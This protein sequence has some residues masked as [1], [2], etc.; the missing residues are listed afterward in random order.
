MK[1]IATHRKEIP[2]SSWVWNVESKELS[3][4]IT[5]LKLFGEDADLVPENFKSEILNAFCSAE[6]SESIP[7]YRKTSHS[8]N[9]NKYFVEWLGEAIERNKDGGISK[10]AGYAELGSSPDDLTLSLNEEAL[11]FTRLMDN[12]RESVYFKDLESRFIRINKACAEKFGLEDPSE[13]VGK[14]D[15]DFFDD[16]HAR[17][18]FKDEQEIIRTE[19]PLF[20]KIE[21]EV[22]AGDS[23][24]VKWASTSK[25]PLYDEKGV[26]I[27]TY[28]ITR[29][30]TEEQI[31]KS[32][33]KESDEMFQRLSEHVPG[34]FY[35]YKFNKDGT[36]CFPFAS[37]GIKHIYELEP[38]DVKNNVDGI[39]SRI[40]PEDRK[41]FTN[42]LKKAVESKSEW[43]CDYR[44]QLPKKGTRWLRGNAT[45]EVEKDN[46]IL[47]YGYIKDI[48][49][50][51]EA[52]EKLKNRN[53]LFT[54]LSEQAP[55]FLYLHRV[56]AK[57]K[58]S[59]PFVSEG[60]REVLEL[61]PKDLRSS[62]KPL[63]RL[64]QKEDIARVMKSITWS[65]KTQQEWSCEFRVIL[66]RK[67]LRW[68]RGRANP[69]LQSDGAVL[70][71]GFLSDITREKS[72]SE[73]ND[74]LRKQFES[75]LDNV[76]N[77]IFVKDLEGKYLMANKAAR[78]FF[79]LSESE[80]IGKT[81]ID[82]GVPE[83]TAKE[84]KEADKRVAT[85]K[86]PLFIPEIKSIDFK[87]NEV[88]H[89]TIKVPF[90]QEGSDEPAVLAVVTDISQ[91]KQ[92]EMQLNETLDIVG[93]QNKRLLNFAHIVSHNL[94][95]HAGNISMLLS[96]FDVEES[97]EE[98]EEL[99]GYLK[100]ASERLNVSIEDLNEIIDQQYKTENDLK[101]LKPSEMIKKVKEI[102][103]SDILS[104]NIQFEE[105]IDQELI[106]EYNPA[107][108]E[109]ITLNLISNAI[110]YRNPDKKAKVKIDLYESN[111]HSYLEVSDNGLGIDLEKHGDKLFGMYKTFHGNENSKG[112]GLFITK[113]QIE[114]LGGSIEVESTPGKGTTF[115]IRLT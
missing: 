21:K 113:N 95:N 6:I 112:I 46:S 89:Q 28:G 26:L 99:M 50:Q 97:E 24:K 11:F 104:Y 2:K 83:E 79:G 43:N 27:G 30:I 69:E 4:G 101:E 5:F 58:V 75:V 49:Q 32:K 91:R 110:K 71:S 29:D 54:K 8:I 60:I 73:L 72:I 85:T 36:S 55:G 7:F 17:P 9:N 41:R 61:E 115:K 93:E 44:V 74:R 90:Q 52:E 94:R 59:F 108:L 13:I 96:L 3:L 106:I 109:S 37:K 51:K 20:N 1:L 15:F 102:L 103:I 114:S 98:K 34:F 68:V 12:I 25:M 100:T 56:D 84:Y 86:E 22:F 10:M 65:V 23:S 78:E 35:Q 92:K 77:L 42:S 82:L 33:L 67:G 31:A 18:A 63:L 76:P 19:K 14:T 80:I 47:G 81:D 16:E 107:Y 62:I 70:S 40:H 53:E 45:L 111:G 64:V 105:N 39:R 87:G 66:P 88:F 57:E 48:T 38:A